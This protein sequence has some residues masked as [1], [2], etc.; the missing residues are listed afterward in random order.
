MALTAQENSFLESLFALADTNNSK[1]SQWEQN[2]VNDHKARYEEYGEGMR[3]SP[4]QWAVLNKID[5][6]LNGEDDG[7]R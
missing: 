1:L 3:I 7:R 5:A 6:K 4:K 2:F